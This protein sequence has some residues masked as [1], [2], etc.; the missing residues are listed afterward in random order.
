M[1][2]ICVQCHE[3]SDSPDDLCM[4]AEIKE[5]GTKEVP[6][7]TRHP[8]FEMREDEV[9]P[10]FQLLS[11]APIQDGQHPVE[12]TDA[13]IDEILRRRAERDGE[14]TKT[15]SINEHAHGFEQEGDMHHT[16]DCDCEDVELV[17]TGLNIDGNEFVHPY[18]DEEPADARHMQY[19][20]FVYPDGD[21]VV[22]DDPAQI[23]GDLNQGA[24]V[25]DLN[26]DAIAV[27]PGF[28]V[29]EW[30]PRPGMSAFGEQL[31]EVVYEDDEYL[32]EAA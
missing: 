13:V 21:E 11:D 8:D 5:A 18:H 26:G 3:I 32:D 15:I 4:P 27:K 16:E 19:V 23:Y 24:L 6:G 22:V 31:E 9:E 12:H 14:P 17:G 2:Y 29:L 28:N 1:R 20:V 25:I 7:K 30:R 10:F